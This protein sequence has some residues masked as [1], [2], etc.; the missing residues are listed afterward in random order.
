MS[1]IQLKA[2]Y[3]GAHLGIWWAIATPLLLAISINF[4]FN[5]AFKVA[6]PGYTLFVLSGIL[7]WFFFA[8]TLGE[9]TES[10]IAKS[11][12]LKQSRLPREFIPLSNILANLLNFLIG[13]ALLSVLFIA[14]DLKVIWFFPYLA[15]SVALN[16]LFVTGMGL[17][18]ATLNVF[19]RDLSHFLSIALMVWFW[20]TP[21]FYSSDMLEFPF[22]WVCLLN[23]VSHYVI[24]YQRILFEARIPS[25]Q[26]FVT[27]AVISAASFIVGYWVFIRNESSLMKKI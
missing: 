12:I 6:M 4:V 5:K 16:F 27:A 3:A 20:I 23:P 11:S 19:L 25:W 24:L 2:K 22:R 17:I 14:A 10:F 7:P 13:L 9:V 1:I 8:G 15:L 26:M 21:V 18:F